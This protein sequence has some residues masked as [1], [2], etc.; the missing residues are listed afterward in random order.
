MHTVKASAGGVQ[1]RSALFEVL[2]GAELQ[3]ARAG[4]VQR[5]DQIRVAG[6]G[7]IKVENR[8]ESRICQ[9]SQPHKNDHHNKRQDSHE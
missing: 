5:A 1:A 4:E 2:L 8:L 7:E 6:C 3:L 9:P